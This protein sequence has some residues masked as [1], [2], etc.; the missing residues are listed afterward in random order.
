M[1]NLH[2]HTTQQNTHYARTH[3]HTLTL[4]QT[5]IHTP[6]IMVLHTLGRQKLDMTN[7]RLKH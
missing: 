5:H 4:I 7:P 3:T 6:I 1:K 2:I